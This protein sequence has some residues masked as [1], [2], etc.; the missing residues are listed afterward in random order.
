MFDNLPIDN[1]VDPGSDTGHREPLEILNDAEA[2]AR[3]QQE[4]KRKLSNIP[5]WRGSVIRM[6]FNWSWC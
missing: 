4:W 6:A 1:R 3:L 5:G 2:L